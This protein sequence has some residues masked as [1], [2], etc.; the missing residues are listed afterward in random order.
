M[1]VADAN[2][3]LYLLVPGARTA[4]AEAVYRQDP[5]WAVPPLCL[6]EVRSVLLRYVRSGGLS[7]ADAERIVA[8]AEGLLAQHQVG[9]DSVAVL[10]LGHQSG[11]SAYDCEYVALAK[12]LAVP[13]VTA[14]RALRVA[15][16]PLTRAPAEFLDR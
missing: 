9:V 11:C 6:S 13:L 14:D 2:L 10:Q 1:I 8:R 5:A 16:G 15:F 4:E 12:A 3:V 7:M